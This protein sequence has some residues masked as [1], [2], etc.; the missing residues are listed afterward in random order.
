MSIYNPSNYV[1]KYNLKHSCKCVFIFLTQMLSSITQDQ[2]NKLPI[3][4]NGLENGSYMRILLSTLQ[5]LK[6]IHFH[7]QACKAF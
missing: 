3:T 7:K 1:L 2:E 4:T 6:S 5:P